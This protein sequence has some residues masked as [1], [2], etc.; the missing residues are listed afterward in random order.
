MRSGS[1]SRQA[2]PRRRLTEHLTRR[3]VG[4]TYT[5]THARTHTHRHTQTHTCPRLVFPISSRCAAALIIAPMPGGIQSDASFSSTL[6]RLDETRVSCRRY[7]DGAGAWGRWGGE[8]ASLRYALP[9]QG[10]PKGRQASEIEGSKGAKVDVKDADGR[11]AGITW[12][13]GC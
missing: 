2:F 5:H 7:R 3:V 8:C 6:S 10:V 13:P 1:S 11:E 4:A 12:T 9:R